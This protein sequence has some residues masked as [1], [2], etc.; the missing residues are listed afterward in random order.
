MFGVFGLGL[1]GRGDTQRITDMLEAAEKLEVQARKDEIVQLALI[2]LIQIIGEAAS[3]VSADLRQR[4]PEI[5]WR[6]VVSMHNRVVRAIRGGPR[7]AVGRGH[8]NVVIL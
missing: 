1:L 2:H 3:R 7:P 5:P 6:Q 8:R 4:H